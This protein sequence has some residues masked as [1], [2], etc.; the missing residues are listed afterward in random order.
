M[1]PLAEENEIHEINQWRE[2][3]ELKKREFALKEREQTNRDV[4]IELRK[5][6]HRQSQWR[7]PLVVTILAAAVAALGNAA[8]NYTNSRL[9]SQVE[10][11]K[12][13]ESRILEMIK[14]GDP[15]KAAE[16][17]QFLL[18]AGL[19]SNQETSQ[20]VSQFLGQRKAGSGPT[21]PANGQN[22]RAFVNKLEYGSEKG[23]D[24]FIEK[25]QALALEAGILTETGIS[26][27]S[28]EV[29][30]GGEGRARKIAAKVE[31][32]LGIPKSNS[33]E[34]K[35]LEKYIELMTPSSVAFGMNTIIARRQ[36]EYRKLLASA[37]WDIPRPVVSS[38]GVKVVKPQPVEQRVVE[39]AVPINTR[40]KKVIQEQLVVRESDIENES[41]FVSDL[42]ADELDEV[43]LIMA[44]EEEFKIE[45]PD[46]EA[47]K[48][49]TPGDVMQ[50]LRKIDPS[51]NIPLREASQQDGS[52]N[53]RR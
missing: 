5:H 41:D 6:E 52:G 18:D 12:A 10:R 35:W 16:N 53:R 25:G 26:I 43:E 15:D 34:K 24:P 7:S 20:K 42:G 1:S 31:S 28:A 39:T 21:L 4:E 44:I 29:V 40:L 51:I 33:A 3:F 30:N 14:T 2:E 37:N 17:L 19:I 48:L 47:E 45:I 22:P 8:V 36:Q 11:Q 46:D 50:F 49:R 23:L 32:I 13:E 38:N 27:I 9:Q